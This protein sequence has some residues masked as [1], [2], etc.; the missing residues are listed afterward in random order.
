MLYIHRCQIPPTCACLHRMLPAM[1]GLEGNSLRGS[2]VDY[3]RKGTVQ[4]HQRIWKFFQS[5]KASSIVAN[6]GMIALLGTLVV[7]NSQGAQVRRV[8]AQPSIGCAVCATFQLT[9]G[10]NIS[11]RVSLKWI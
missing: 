3:R 8:Q 9:E 11:P 4:K 6:V 7:G 2:Q 5:R 1:R 10:T